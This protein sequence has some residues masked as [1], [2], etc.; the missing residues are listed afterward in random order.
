MATIRNLT[1]RMV[2]FDLPALGT[3]THE[4]GVHV[5]DPVSG[6][7]GFRPHV[8]ELPESLTLAASSGPRKALAEAVA[9]GSA[10]DGLPDA[11]VDD[12][13]VVRRVQRRE[14]S[15]V[16]SAQPAPTTHEVTQ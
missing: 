8:R 14:M 12:P 1:T 16:K 6:L 13:E 10:V 3:R 15:A 9:E 5:H 4:G 7:K 11:V 2:A